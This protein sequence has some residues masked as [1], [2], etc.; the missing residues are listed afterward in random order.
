M[1][2]QEE[3][4]RVKTLEELRQE[5]RNEQVGGRERDGL[6]VMEQERRRIR[7]QEEEDLRHKLLEAQRGTADKKRAS[8]AVVAD[9]PETEPVSRDQ[10]VQHQSPPSDESGQE[11]GEIDPRAEPEGEDRPAKRQR[12]DVLPEDTTWNPSPGQASRLSIGG[13]S[14]S[15]DPRRW[16]GTNNKRDRE[17]DRYGNWREEG[18]G[19]RSWGGEGRE[20][21]DHRTRDLREMIGRD[22]PEYNDRRHSTGRGQ[23]GE[24]DYQPIRGRKELDSGRERKNRAI[25]PPHRPRDR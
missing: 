7:K 16:E 5:K 12:V 10:G 24:R 2:R 25:S 15:V 23:E 11:E 8:P 17:E 22:R 3:E 14:R 13:R 1:G 19:G 21:N 9:K 6:E 4:V 20:G 18:K